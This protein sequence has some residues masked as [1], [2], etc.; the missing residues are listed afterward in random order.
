MWPISIEMVL[1]SIPIQF[2]CPYS[3]QDSSILML[4]P[5][6]QFQLSLLDSSSS[7]ILRV[8]AHSSQDRSRI[9][10]ALWLV[11]EGQGLLEI[12]LYLE[13]SRTFVSCKL[14]PFISVKITPNNLPVDHVKCHLTQQSQL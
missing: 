12:R 6:C 7:S 5:P 9:L 8:P 14:F 13:V 11:N 1:V 2:Q 4:G 3:K 10:S